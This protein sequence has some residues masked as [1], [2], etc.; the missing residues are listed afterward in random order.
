MVKG[1]EQDTYS[2]QGLCTYG[3]SSWMLFP[4]F[5]VWLFPSGH[6]R[7]SLNMPSLE[8]LPWLHRHS[9]LPNFYFLCSIHHD[10]MNE[11]FCWLICLLDTSVQFSRSFVPNSLR[12]H[13]LQHAR[14]PC[15]SPTLGACSN[16][17][18]LNPWCHPTISSSHPFSSSPQS[19]PA[20][21]SF[22]MSLLFTSGGQSIG[23]SA[24]V[25]PMNI[26]GWFPL[27]LTGL[28]SLQSKGLSRVFSSTTQFKSIISLVTI[29]SL[30]IF[31]S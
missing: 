2:P 21:G 18:P 27:G 30:D 24:S 31:L 5:S 1:R 10:L 11:L 20:P 7:L 8:R 16:S 23:A 28:I 29:Y 26:Q 12:P 9:F 17:C 6:S 22:S 4:E 19:I 13:G 14:P 25:L 3:T 15:P